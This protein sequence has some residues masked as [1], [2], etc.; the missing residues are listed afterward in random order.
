[1]DRG[2]IGD[3][4]AEFLIE[5]DRGLAAVDNDMRK[6]E[7][8]DPRFGFVH[9]APPEFTPAVFRQNDNSPDQGGRRIDR[10]DPTGRDGEVLVGQDDILRLRR[11]FIVKLPPKRDS[12]LFRHP[13][14]AH[15][16]RSR[17][18]PRLGCSDYLEVHN[19]FPLIPLAI[20]PVKD[21]LNVPGGKNNH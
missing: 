2:G 3:R 7:I 14:D 11:V 20:I 16:V 15:V 1:M 13:L 6:A 5:A 9:H 12:V 10:I 18:L 4:E 8:P 21:L 19:W 17:P